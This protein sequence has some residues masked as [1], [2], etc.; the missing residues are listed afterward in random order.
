MENATN[1]QVTSIT[2][3]MSNATRQSVAEQ[4]CQEAP[5]DEGAV[6][7]IVGDLTDL[8]GLSMCAGVPAN[9]YMAVSA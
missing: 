5:M 3:A 1:T 4:V 8:Y 9:D 7:A 6:S 2:D